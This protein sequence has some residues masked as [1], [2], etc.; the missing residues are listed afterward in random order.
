MPDAATTEVLTDVYDGFVAGDLERVGRGM[1]DDVVAVDPPEVVDGG[2]FEGREAVLGR[3]AGFLELFDEIELLGLGLEDI[4]DRVL[5][6]F[7]ARGRAH[8]GGAQADLAIVH[9]IRMRDG[10][11]AE[12][13]VFF[14]EVAARQF[15]AHP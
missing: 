11:V 4:G 15:V 14:D 3:L 2:T 13:R 8:I 10:K 5:A 12:L 6:T 7:T 1:T 9:L